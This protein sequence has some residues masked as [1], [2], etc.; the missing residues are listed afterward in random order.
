MTDNDLINTSKVS[1]TSEMGGQ[2]FRGSAT[3]QDL[4]SINKILDFLKGYNHDKV[5]DLGCGYGDFTAHVARYLSI[6]NVYGVDIDNER[7]AQARAQGISTNNLDLDKDT[8]PFTDGYFDLVTSFGAL[9][10]LICFDNF[11]SESYRILS[12]K[13]HIVIAMPNLAS[14]INR[15]A[16]RFGYQPRDVEISHKAL[17][18]TLPFYHYSSDFFGHIHSATLGS[19]KQL[20]EYHGFR[21]IKVNSS[22]P[23]QNNW[24]VKVLDIVF[25]FSSGFSRRFIILGRKS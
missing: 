3:A 7:L 6:K 20:M 19:I 25:S 15:I 1:G 17:P 22:S 2:Q 10:H 4:R 23:Y 5:I 9:E 14:Y 18:G 24:I 11:F 13:G 16:L 12:E 8:L 21:T